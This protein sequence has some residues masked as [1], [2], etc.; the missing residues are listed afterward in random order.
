MSVLK[1]DQR[2]PRKLLIHQRYAD[3]IGVRRLQ[4]RLRWIRA[5]RGKRKKQDDKQERCSRSE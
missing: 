2:F 1:L 4:I 5:P 3:I